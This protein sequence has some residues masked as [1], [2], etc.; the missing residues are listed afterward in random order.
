MRF[1]VLAGVVPSFLAATALAPI[2]AAGQRSRG[3]M[4]GSPGAK[5]PVITTGS[6]GAAQGA[7]RRPAARPGTPITTGRH[8]PRI[9]HTGRGR[10]SGFQ[11]FAFCGTGLAMP[12]FCRSRVFAFG[13]SP[14]GLLGDGAF[15]APF[16]APPVEEE[17]EGRPS[18]ASGSELIVVS[19]GHALDA[20]TVRAE[21]RGIVRLTRAATNGAID[22]VTL[23]LA[24]SAQVVL[25]RQTLSAAPY[26]ALFDLSPR[27]AYVG[28]TV[29][30]GDGSRTTQLI[31]Y[32]PVAR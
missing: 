27:T 5:L 10:P 23:F 4:G 28:M 13:F 9:I 26:S 8:L 24:D 30:Y 15:L 14:F 22:E 20:L 31:P 12:S 1:V 29:T 2:S 32:V 21:G 3:G 11:R 18:A 7:R 17:D 19:P 25:A 16:V 6:A